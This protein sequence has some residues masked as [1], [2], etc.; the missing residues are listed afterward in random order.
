MKP[1]ENFKLSDVPMTRIMLATTSEPDYEMSRVMIAEDWPD[2]GDYTVIAG[3][4]CSCYG[5]D[6]TQWDATCYTD[7]ELPKVLASWHTS[8]DG[9]ERAMAALWSMTGR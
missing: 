9:A 6:D 7:D 4:H 1:I 2:Y 3:S 8:Y 5:F